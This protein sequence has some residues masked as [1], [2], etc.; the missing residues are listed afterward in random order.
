[1]M[2]TQPWYRELFNEEYLRRY[3]PLLTPERTEA[4]AEAVVRLLNLA[5]GSRV[6]DLCCGHGRHAIALA[7]RGHEVTGLDLCELFLDRARAR[8]AAAGVEVRW[9]HS[10]MRRIPFR[11]EFAATIN[12]FTA[13]GYLESDEEDQEVLR[14]VC[15]ALKP[16]GRFLME[17]LHRD[18]LLR[19]H[20]PCS[21]ERR[22]DGALM[23][24]E[25]RFDLLAGRQE[26][27]RTTIYPDGT[28]AEQ[29]LSLRLYTAAELARLFRTAGLEVEAAYGDLDGGPL[30]LESR[31]MVLIGR[32]E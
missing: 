1:M 11:G 15:A 19:R 2:E 4:D 12:M 20:L 30:T 25:R 28:R 27:V 8:A 9:V 24:D 23:L 3:E 17:I 22:D 31:R 13:F 10:D 16:G 18:N 7:R 29:R 26:E 14:Q 21:I 6:L 32:K 5:P